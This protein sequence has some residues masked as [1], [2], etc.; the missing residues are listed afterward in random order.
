MKISHILDTFT[1]RLNKEWLPNFCHAPH[2]NYSTD[3]FKEQSISKLNDYDAYWFLKAID[4]GL[5]TEVDGFF[6]APLSKAKEQIFWTGSKKENP[7]PLTLWVEPIITIGAVARLNMEFDW[8]IGKLGTQSKT[9]AFDLVGYGKT[10]TEEQLVCEVKKATKEIEEL[11]HFMR[12]Y[13]NTPH[14]SSEP[15]NSKERNAYRKVQGIRRSWP[16]LFWALGP[17]GEGEVYN[18]CRVGNSQCFDLNLIEESSL[19]YKSS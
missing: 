14:L 4:S 15:K 8:P 5:V 16:L 2:R 18:I 1:D 10:S 7:R 11:M 9:W 17:K 3:G 6:T 12:M 19:K 13:C